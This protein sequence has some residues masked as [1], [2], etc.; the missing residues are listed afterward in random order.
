MME[1]SI[2]YAV[3]CKGEGRY[4]RRRILFVF[5]YVAFVLAFFLAFCAVNIPQVVA[6]C[7]ILLLILVLAT[8]RYTQVTNE[9]TIE[10][11]DISFA[12]IYGNRTRR[13]YLKIP[14]KELRAVAPVEKCPA[15]N[16]KRS[17]E[18]RGSTKSPDSYY[19]IFLDK[20]G[21]EAIVYFEATRKALRLFSLYNPSVVT[22]KKDLRY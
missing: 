13:E 6:L 20:N 21:E 9:Y 12:R 22:G 15:K 3:D 11:G 5:L 18:F 7:P 17:Y 16:Y 14:V 4:G 10:V 19:L 1:N 8:W 2:I